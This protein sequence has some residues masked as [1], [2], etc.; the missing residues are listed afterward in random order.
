MLT[1]KPASG[2]A[3]ADHVPR[4]DNIRGGHPVRAEPGATA[5]LTWPGP[6]YCGVPRC[7]AAAVR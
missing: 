3:A 5:A 1:P 7:F 2:I 6:T 4:L